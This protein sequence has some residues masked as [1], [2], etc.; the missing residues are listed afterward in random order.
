M[1]RPALDLSARGDSQRR[2]AWQFLG[3]GVT[4]TSAREAAEQAGLNW[5][6]SLRD[7]YAL[8]SDQYI[9][10][11]D[12]FATVRNNL[13][14]SKSILGV[15]GGRYK[16]FQNGEM[17]SVLDSIVDSGEA[18]YSAAGELAGGSVVWM[19][20]ELPREVRIEQDPH[21]AYLLA[22]T[23]HDGSCSL[24]IAPIVQRIGCT[25]QISAIFAKTEMK[26][27][28]R[29]TT[30]AD[31]S[32]KDVRKMLTTVYTG[33]DTYESIAD[34][35]L[36][37]SVDESDVDRFLTQLFPIDSKLAGTPYSM[38][39][40]GERKQYNKAMDSRDK[41]GR[42]YRGETGTQDNIH[43]TAFG[44]WHAA[45]EYADHYSVADATKR[46]TRLANG[47]FDRFKSKALAVA[48]A[49]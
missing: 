36:N 44:L 13:D 30:N 33:I 23:S 24:Q 39:S 46:A 2:N 5:Q 40:T 31:L 27:S 21:A 11:A 18:R 26:Y 6:V 28:L 16:V 49:A 12:K 15:V 8:D 9:P 20:L 7:V 35:L 17:F 43:G 47:G 32:I 14:G 38:M 45:I 4:A 22:R 42:I 3:R 48:S 34:R 41:V 10:V 19:L 25:N 37:V 1:A 29:H